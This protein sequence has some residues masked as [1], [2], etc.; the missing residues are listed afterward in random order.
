MGT[1]QSSINQGLGTIAGAA[2]MAKHISNQNKELKIKKEDQ[3]F[4]AE[5][6]A[7]ELGM[8][9]MMLE[10]EV[11]IHESDNANMAE[12]RP[13]FGTPAWESWKEAGTLSKEEQAFERSFARN[14]QLANAKRKQIQSLENRIKVL[15]G[16]M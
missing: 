4:A 2:T 3:K 11:Q 7:N 6:E 8:K 16:R 14:N 13:E 10:D 5:A 1:I 15:G 12:D 9:K